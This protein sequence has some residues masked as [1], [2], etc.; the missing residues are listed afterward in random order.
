MLC[1]APKEPD[2]ERGKRDG[3]KKPPWAAE[4]AKDLRVFF[5]LGRIRGSIDILTGL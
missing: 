3:V 2:R 5:L 4:R 1:D